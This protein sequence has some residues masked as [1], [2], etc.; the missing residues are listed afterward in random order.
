MG[1]QRQYSAT[2]RLI[3]RIFNLLVFSLIFS[4]SFGCISSGDPARKSAAAA[5]NH[6]EAAKLRR[7]EQQADNTVVDLNKHLKLSPIGR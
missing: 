2:N 5:A 1:Q 7:T 6:A 3:S 4:H